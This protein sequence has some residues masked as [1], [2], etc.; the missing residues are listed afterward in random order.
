MC[1]GRADQR[2]DWLQPGRQKNPRERTKPVARELA[3]KTIAVGR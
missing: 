3:K 1:L 2:A